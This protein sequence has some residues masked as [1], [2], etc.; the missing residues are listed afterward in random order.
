MRKTIFLRL[1]LLCTVALCISALITAVLLQSDIKVD[2]VEQNLALLKAADQMEGLPQQPQELAAALSDL[3]F[4]Y[5]VT[6][7]APEG[8][9]LGDSHVALEQLENHLD[10]P[11]VA[12]ALRNGAASATRHSKTM[13]QEMLYVALLRSN[14]TVLRMQITIQ[15]LQSLLH[16]QL[17]AV[18]LGLVA[19]LLV[20]LW[21]SRAL[22][23]TLL[24]PVE[25]IAAGIQ[26]IEEG[27]YGQ[28]LPDPP[29]EEYASLTANVNSLSHTVESSLA[30]LSHERD[31]LHFLLNSM[32]QGVVVVDGW[33]RIVLCNNS[34]AT[35]LGESEPLEGKSLYNLTHRSEILSNVEKCISTRT[36]SV[37]DLPFPA[38]SQIYSVSIN[39]VNSQWLEVGV[40]II[41]TDVT[42]TRKAEK[43]RREFVANAS[44]E[45]KTPVTSIRGFAELLASGIVIDPERVKDY[46]RRIENES[47]R[48]DSLI[49][50]ILRLSSL[51][52]NTKPR[53]LQRLSLWQ[54]AEE[55]IGDLQ[56]QAKNKEVTLH[57][58]GEEVYITADK[59]DM[60]QLLTNLTENAIK[61]NVPGGKVT[62]TLGQDQ[63]RTL[64][65]VSDTG[66]GIPEADTIRIFERFYR[67]DKGRSRGVGGTGLGLSIVKHIVSYYQGKIEVKSRLGQ[68]TQI[69]VTI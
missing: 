64:I 42:E 46:L 2:Q 23:N 29:Y 24:K 17:P 50:D 18:L 55:I 53:N 56:I 22:T 60:E 52:E 15:E 58:G 9:V 4:N 6:I 10:R 8:Q 49:S 47:A 25:E 57:L 13:G 66:I 59:L 16:A 7:I 27:N 11:E 63:G 28:R 65:C 44:H 20:A 43:L 12:A 19:S 41:F 69:F 67:V 31:K 34:A 1:M 48:M 30:S 40:I 14:G 37:F 51:E 35:L 39:P 21:M 62:I 61:Y 45:L 54:V 3:Y 38:Q 36:S 5:R 33:M 26:R 32:R 68:G